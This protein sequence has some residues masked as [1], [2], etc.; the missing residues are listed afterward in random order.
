RAVIDREG[1]HQQ[2]AADLDVLAGLDADYLA[3]RRMA[4]DVRPDPHQRLQG[5]FRARGWG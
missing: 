1:T 4:L 2:I 3:G 5:G